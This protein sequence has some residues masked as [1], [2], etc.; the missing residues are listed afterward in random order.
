M[1][2]LLV[3]EY[4]WIFV[5]FFYCTASAVPFS[6]STYCLCLGCVE[7][8]N[9]IVVAET[10]K[11]RMFCVIQIISKHSRLAVT[12]GQKILNLDSSADTIGANC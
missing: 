2:Q 8:A 12:K 10:N 4:E 9:A 6:P 1:L 11:S 5:G 3:G 7:D